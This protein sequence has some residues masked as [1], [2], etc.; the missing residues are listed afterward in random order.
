VRASLVDLE[1]VGDP[2]GRS[3]EREGDALLVCGLCDEPTKLPVTAMF[4]H[5]RREHGFDPESVDLFEKWPD[6]EIVI[7]D[8]AL[9]P[10]DFA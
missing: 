2:C 3:T 7:V 1:A 5:M 8:S 9:E 6:G 4:E 10:E